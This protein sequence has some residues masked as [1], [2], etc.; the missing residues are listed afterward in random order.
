[1][2]GVQHPGLPQA[3]GLGLRQKAPGDGLEVFAHAPHAR[4]AVGVEVG[5]HAQQA[6]AIAG[7]RR[8]RVHVHALVVGAHRLRPRLDLLGSKAG[9]RHAQLATVFGQQ[10]V[11]QLQRLAPKAPH[12]GAQRLLLGRAAGG[13][14]QHAVGAQADVARAGLQ[15]VFAQQ[16]LFG[17]L[18]VEAQPGKMQHLAGLDGGRPVGLAARLAPVGEVDL[19]DG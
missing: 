6:F 5:E 4:H 11:D 12:H 3:V 2:H 10:A 18:Q 9:R 7:A 13:A 15:H 19:Y 16:R 8:E 14:L 1:V 17:R